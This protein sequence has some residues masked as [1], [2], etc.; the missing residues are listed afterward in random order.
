MDLGATVEADDQPLEVVKV[1]EGRSTTQRTR[2][3]PEPCSVLRRVITGL[4]PVRGRGDGARR[5]RSRGP[6]RPRLGGNEVCRPRRVWLYQPGSGPSQSPH[7]RSHMAR[8]AEGVLELARGLQLGEQELVQPLPT[9]ARCH[10]S[11]RR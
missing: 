4:T 6:Q 7:F 3:S 2:P 1:S 8:V 11:R 9:P 10:S 5:G